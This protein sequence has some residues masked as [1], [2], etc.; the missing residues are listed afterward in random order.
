MLLALQQYQEEQQSVCSQ[1]NL[2][3]QRLYSQTSIKY[4]T[5]ES[6]IFGILQIIALHDL[7]PDQFYK[8][9]NLLDTT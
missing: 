3:H 2:H 4:E 9:M 7:Y 1:F 8:Y 5:K 6:G